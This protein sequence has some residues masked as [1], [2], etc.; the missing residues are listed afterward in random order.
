[1]IYSIYNFI[2]NQH[3]MKGASALQ[4]PF[5]PGFNI[6]PGLTSLN[7]NPE[8]ISKPDPTSPFFSLKRDHSALFDQP[9][10]FD[11]RSDSEFKKDDFRRM[12]ELSRDEDRSGQSSPAAYSEL[13][14]RLIH[15]NVYQYA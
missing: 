3:K 7:L 4:S 12:D 10:R 15:L 11:G 8:Y 9:V 14:V 5:T 2:I 13:K 1:M 6:N